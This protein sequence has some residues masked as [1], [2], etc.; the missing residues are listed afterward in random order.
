MPKE[1]QWVRGDYDSE[2]LP[3]EVQALMQDAIFKIA[4]IYG[5]DLKE[6][7][8]RKVICYEILA[9]IVDEMDMDDMHIYVEGY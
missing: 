6:N 5:I 2:R 4:R 3:V 7:P 1:Q 8:R 9:K